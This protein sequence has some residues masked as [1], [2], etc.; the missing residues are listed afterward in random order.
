[1][2]LRLKEQSG[3]LGQITGKLGNAKTKEIFKDTKG[4]R[5]DP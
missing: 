4:K 2:G 1:M 3:P 5:H